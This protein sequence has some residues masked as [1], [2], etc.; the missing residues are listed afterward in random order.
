MTV[1]I[2]VRSC[3][4]VFDDRGGHH[5]AR[6]P[7][8]VLRL[9]RATGRS[10]PARTTGHRRRRRRPGRQLRGQGVR[11]AHGDGRSSG[12][13]S[14]S[15]GHRRRPPDVG[16]HRGEPGGLRG[17]QRHHT[18]RRGHLDRRGVP[19]RG[20]PAS[21]V[22]HSDRDRDPPAPRGTRPRGP[23][24]HGR[25][26]PDQVPGQGGERGGQTRRPAGGRLP[27]A[28]STS[29]TRYRSSASGASVR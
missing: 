15:D 19:G 10:E 4:H 5:P 27:M 26:G 28:S 23:A 16:L 24:H 12:P 1:A 29:C 6:R 2:R 13:P 14:L 22:R 9:G 8:C 25:G 18:A 20:G 7:R 21:V 11:G 3:E 17:L